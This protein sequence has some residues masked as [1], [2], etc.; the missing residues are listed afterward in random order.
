MTSNVPLTND[1][2]KF[3]AL[4]IADRRRIGYLVAGIC[5]VNVVQFYIAPPGTVIGR[6]AAMAGNALGVFW[7]VSPEH[8][9]R[10]WFG[11]LPIGWWVSAI[12]DGLQVVRAIQQGRMTTPLAISSAV[13]V[14]LL[15]FVAPTLLRFYRLRPSVMQAGSE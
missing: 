13:I 12:F 2:Q 9:P 7:S 14:L 1:K 6:W 3:L 15:L 4:P 5:A 8:A 10:F 11:L